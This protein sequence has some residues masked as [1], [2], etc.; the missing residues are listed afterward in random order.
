M[1]STHSIAVVTGGRSGERD[2]SLISGMAVSESLTRQS[3][4]H[5]VLDLADAE[6]PNRV[7]DAGVAFLAIA[8]R[9]AEDGKLQGTLETLGVPYTGSGVL[10]SALGMHKPTAKNVVRSVGVAV[11]P[12]VVIG[13]GDDPEV[14]V[15]NVANL[16]WPVILKPCSEGG[17]IGTEVFRDARDLAAVLADNKD[18]EWLAEPFSA[19]T[20]VTCGVITRGGE[21]VPLPPLE[22]VPTT[23]EFY[24]YA[25]KRDPNAYRYRCPAELPEPTMAAIQRAALDAHSALGCHSYSRSD[26][27]VT[28]TRDLYWLEVNTLPGL[29]VHG[30]LATMASAAKI[31]YDELVVAILESAAHSRYRP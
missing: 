15:R 23:A 17:S 16:G 19:G 13:A 31:S 21:L 20:A 6:F 8:G 9:W 11:L 10:A 5:V 7:R 2:R 18:E 27:I 3:I 29:S 30:N 14:A 4:D 26:F 24:D 1:A 25:A 28:P 22:T 12:H